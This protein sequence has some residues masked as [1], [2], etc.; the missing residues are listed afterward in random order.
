MPDRAHGEAIDPDGLVASSRSGSPAERSHRRGADVVL[1]G[2][3]AGAGSVARYGVE[4]LAGPG[5]TSLW[6][7]NVFGSALLGV[8]VGA[9]STGRPERRFGRPRSGRVETTPHRPG[10]HAPPSWVSPLLGTG[11]LGGFTTFSTAA[12]AADLLAAPERT[13]VLTGLGAL[14][15]FGSLVAMTVACVVVAAAGWWLGRGTRR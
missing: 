5:W 4:L 12:V 8:L 6:V 11:V 14:A 13:G 3:G 9:L 2:L 15:A 10:P 1:V 7:V